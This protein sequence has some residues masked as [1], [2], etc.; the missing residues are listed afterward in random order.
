MRKV[1]EGRKKQA[2]ERK[3]KQRDRIDR[4]GDKGREEEIASGS[5]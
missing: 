3:R 1:N 5:S 2:K 4:E